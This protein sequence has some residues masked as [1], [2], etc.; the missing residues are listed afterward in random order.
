[1]V[2]QHTLQTELAIK[3]L[4][5]TI[6]ESTEDNLSFIIDEIKVLYDK[7]LKVQTLSQDF[8]SGSYYF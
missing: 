7:A 3:H 6:K 2:H 8:N 5:N 4:E 1:M